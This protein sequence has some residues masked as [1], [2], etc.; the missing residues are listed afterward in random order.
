ME[1]QKTKE[2]LQAKEK[3]TGSKELKAFIRTIPRG[4]TIQD[5]E[6]TYKRVLND[7]LLI[8]KA[9]RQGITNRLFTEIKENSPFDDLQ[10]SNFLDINVRTL[11][12]YK[13]NK[14]YVYKSLQ[15]ERIFELAEVVN[16]GNAV[17]DSPEHFQ[18]W[19]N[20]PSVALEREKPLDLLNSSY[21]KD[22]IIAELNR[23]EY[24]VFV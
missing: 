24:G 8:A 9:V 18:I 1:R 20:T 3:S 14:D 16:L 19:L 7:K 5:K 10:W 6:V 4:Q 22:L 13:G 17:F 15:S 21:G 12:R 2:K 11:Q 23:I